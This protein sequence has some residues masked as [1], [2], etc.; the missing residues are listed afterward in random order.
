MTEVREGEAPGLRFEQGPWVRHV[1]VSDPYEELKGLVELMDNNPVV[2]ADDF[3]SLGGFDHRP[4]RSRPIA[5]AGL[6]IEPPTFLVNIDADEEELSAFL[7]TVGWNDGV[8][9]H[10][11]PTDHGEPSPPRR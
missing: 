4:G 7:G 11:Q 3:R 10:A 8:T 6:I 5:A 2:C 1:R 9:L